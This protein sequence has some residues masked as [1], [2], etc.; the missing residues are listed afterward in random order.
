MAKT[1]ADK[2]YIRDSIENVQT[3]EII[4]SEDKLKN[5]LERQIRWIKKSSGVLSYL[6]MAVT[7]VG[8]LVSTDFKMKFGITPDMW[9]TVFFIASIVFGGLFLMSSF[10]ALFHRVT[11]D[12]IVTD[13][14][15]ADS[16]K[17]GSCFIDKW[18]SISKSNRIKADNEEEEQK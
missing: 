10:Y 1:S 12:S 14:K 13:L 3:N 5:K 4:I 7:C 2:K 11:V 16:L 18:K 9:K 6:S 17:T 15:T 8:I